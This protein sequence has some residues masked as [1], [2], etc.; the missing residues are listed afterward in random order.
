MAILKSRKF[1]KGEYAG[2]KI[3]V[4]VLKYVTFEK[5]GSLVLDDVEEDDVNEFIRLTVDSFDFEV[6]GDDGD[7]DTGGQDE[8]K[9][10]T[11][12]KKKEENDKLKEDL[13]A[14]DI[15][16]LSQLLDDAKI[17]RGEASKWT[18]KKLRKEL[19]KKL[20]A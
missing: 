11:A 9:K 18:D 17:D 3:N 10:E 15:V 19:Y 1:T 5:D 2:Q 4:P 20:A 13:E 14:M 12:K 16:A 8:D 7:G 6:V